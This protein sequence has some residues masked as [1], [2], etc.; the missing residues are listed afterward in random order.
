[1]EQQT[2]PNPDL[3]APVA[4]D[5][6]QGYTIFRVNVD[7][8][9]PMIVAKPVEPDWMQWTPTPAPKPPTIIWA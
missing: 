3:D 7:R 5:E 8:D 6:V 1:M 2:R 9:L 4:A